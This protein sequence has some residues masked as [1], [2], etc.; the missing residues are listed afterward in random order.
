MKIHTKTFRVREG[1]NVDLKKWPTV[2]DPVYKSNA[3]YKGLLEKHVSQLSD[4]QH[5]HYA[6]N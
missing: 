6:S 5:L 4:M 1:D 2:V 3:Q